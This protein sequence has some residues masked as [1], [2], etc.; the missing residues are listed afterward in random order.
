MWAAIRPTLTR[1][2]W[3]NPTDEIIH[4]SPL[5]NTTPIAVQPRASRPSIS[6]PVSNMWLDQSN[7]LSFQQTLRRSSMSPVPT[8][9]LRR[10]LFQENLHHNAWDASDTGKETEWSFEAALSAICFCLVCF[11]SFSLSWMIHDVPG[12]AITR[13]FCSLCNTIITVRSD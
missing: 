12:A 8:T 2:F 11:R 1:K 13:H 4:N 9:Y 7:L 3:S 10:Y 5:Y 6:L